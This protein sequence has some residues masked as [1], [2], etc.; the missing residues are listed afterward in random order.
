MSIQPIDDIDKNL[1]EFN[2]IPLDGLSN[3]LLSI[4]GIIFNQKT[5]K[6][7]ICEYNQ[8]DKCYAIKLNNKRHQLK[9]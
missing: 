6:F 4:N 5:N 7:K 8:K 3:Y 1:D 9:L 2:T